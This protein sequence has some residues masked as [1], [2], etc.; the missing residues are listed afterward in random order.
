MTATPR[1]AEAPRNGRKL[2][3]DAK[4]HSRSAA[5]PRTAAAPQGAAAPRTA[6][7]PR[8]GKTPRTAAVPRSSKILESGA[9]EHSRS[10]ATPRTAAAP[11]GAATPRTAEAPR[12]GKTPRTAEAPQGAA[13]P[14]T[15][16]ALK[17]RSFTHRAASAAPNLKGPLEAPAEYAQIKSA[18]KEFCD[19]N[20]R[21]RSATA[22]ASADNA[23]HERKTNVNLRNLILSSTLPPL[24]PVGQEVAHATNW[25]LAQELLPDELSRLR[26]I[27]AQYSV[28]S[29]PPA[30][31]EASLELPG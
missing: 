5:T 28:E 22:V 23:G 9:K 20:A 27:F 17:R 2:E 8:M 30:Q 16:V 7:A 4:E 26:A 3:G 11:Q 12:M 21:I 25:R 15:A 10:A 31:T 29:C 1:T 24:A 19:L 14:R 18:R 13:T 6:E